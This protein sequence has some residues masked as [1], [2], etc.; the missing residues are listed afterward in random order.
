MA[1]NREGTDPLEGSSGDWYIVREADVEFD[2]DLEELFDQETESEV[3]GLIDDT[4]QEEGNPLQLYQQQSAEEDQQLCS[5]LKRKY[6]SSPQDVNALSPRIEALKILSSGASCARKRLFQ[7]QDEAPNDAAQTQVEGVVD[8]ETGESS[9]DDSVES[10]GSSSSHTDIDCVRDLLRTSNIKATVLSKVKEAFAV[11]ATELYRQFRSDKTCATDWVV[12]GYGV[13]SLFIT[14]ALDVLKPHCEF[15]K[16]CS[17]SCRDKLVFV[18]LLQ[19][20]STKSRETVTKLLSTLFGLVDKQLIIEPPKIRSVP[21]A[22]FWLRVHGETYGELP[23]WVKRQTTVTQQLGTPRL[24]E[25]TQMVQ[26][27][28]DNNYYEE[29]EIAYNYAKLGEEDENARAFLS[30]NSQPKYVRDCVSMLRYYRRAEMQGMSMAEWV[31]HCV[32]QIDDG[33]DWREIV[34]YLR[35]QNIGFIQFAGALKKL[36]KGVPK[37]NCLVVYGPPNTGKTLFCLSMIRCLRG[38]V[39]SYVN[40]K[41]Q[42]WLMPLVDAKIAMIDDATGPCWDYIDIYMRNA[43]DGN[44]IS[45]DRKHC[46]PIQIK[47]PPLL[48]TSNINLLHDDRWRYLHSRV[49]L[50]NFETPMPLKDDG[51]PAYALTEVNWKCFFQRFREHLELTP[52]EPSEDG[53]ESRQPLRLCTGGDSAVL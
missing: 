6:A 38:R 51:S 28:Y 36:L 2:P 31:D 5:K 3:S 18:C 13:T 23:D 44:E 16:L 14:G 4:E 19:F 43:V 47:C 21:A 26:W 53:G 40:S 30:S 10:S 8:T 25:L 29:S 15:V 39:L 22:L 46:N 24:F 48:I 41:S 35:L 37:S 1:T 50:F 27:A 45:V 33:G 42:F 32:S 7:K 12:C 9:L 34:K 17:G 49:Q 52:P 11:S 20:I